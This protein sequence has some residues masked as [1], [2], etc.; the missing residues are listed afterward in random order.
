MASQLRRWYLLK[1]LTGYLC[2]ILISIASLSLIGCSTGKKNFAPVRSSVRDL[3]RSKKY[4]TRKYY[5]V[6]RGDT[7][8]S[9]GFR[10]RLGFLK[11]AAWN[12]ISP[13]YH[14]TVGQRVNLYRPKKA[15]KKRVV[16]KKTVAVVRKERGSSQKTSRVERSTS[17]KKSTIS[18][19]N[20]KVLKFNSQWPLKGK[21]IKNFSQTDKTGIDILGKEGQKVRS[22]DSGKVVYSGSGL[23]A[24]GKLLII[25]HNNLYLSAYAYN[26]KL[27]VK[28]GQFVKKGQAIAEVGGVGRTNALLHFEIRKNGNSVNPLNY[29]PKR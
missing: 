29:L 22:V 14:L 6:K 1:V 25:K 11:L 3:V 10:S 9:I 26:Q 15:F 21:V 7:L 24:Y 5:I 18:T 27:F 12:N 4:K 23:K 28:E 16:R 19:D 8:Y 2:I 13:P 20:K 17:Q